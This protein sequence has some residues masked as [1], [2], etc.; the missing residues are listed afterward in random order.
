MK[1]LL[2]SLT[3]ALLACSSAWASEEANESKYPVRFGVGVHIGFNLGGALPPAVPKPVKKVHAFRPGG[4]PNLGLDFTYRLA[5]TSPFSIATGIEYDMKYF[6]ST[7]RAEEMPIR[8]QNDDRKEQL[9]SGHQSVEYTNRYV[10]IPLG[11]TFDMPKGNFRF[12]VGGYYAHSLK[13]GFTAKLD[14]DGTMDGRTY[15]AGTVLSF[16]LKEALVRNDVGVRFG[17]D[18][19]VDEHWAITGRMNVGLPKLFDK[20]FNVMPYSLRNVFLNLGIS[21]RINR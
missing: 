12:F 11:V 3:L 21:Y 15:L 9:Y 8:Y 5:K 17:A 1:N 13:R 19:K 20:S 16:D 4:A 14:G 18:Y 7:V 2:A 6:Q 10:T